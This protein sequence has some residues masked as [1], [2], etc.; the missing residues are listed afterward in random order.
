MAELLVEDQ[1]IT[2]TGFP[3]RVHAY[4]IASPAVY[5]GLIPMTPSEGLHSSEV[6]WFDRNN[7][8]KSADSHKKKA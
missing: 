7:N 5:C 1:K 6:V 8:T 2:C 3:A 4:V